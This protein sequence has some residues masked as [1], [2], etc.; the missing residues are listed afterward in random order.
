MVP[1]ASEGMTRTRAVSKK[2]C[3]MGLSKNLIIKSEAFAHR[4]LGQD[5][6]EEL[7]QLDYIIGPMTRNDEYLHPQR[8]KIKGHLGSLSYFREDT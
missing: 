8:K 3:G 2:S 5:R 7:S 4:H 1:Y 6:K